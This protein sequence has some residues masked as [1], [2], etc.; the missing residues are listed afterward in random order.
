MSSQTSQ[1]ISS[2]MDAKVSG[3]SAWNKTADDVRFIT[4]ISAADLAEIEAALEHFK[5]LQRNGY[6]VDA[7]TFP[8]PTLGP[9]LD[10]IAQNLHEGTGI[11]LLRGLD[12]K[13][14]DEDYLI[15]FLGLGSYIGSQRGKKTAAFRDRR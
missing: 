11:S 15:I 8:L 4:S 7:S 9:R 6:E 2:K 13:Y 12:T 5:A 3:P 1:E 14:S 10:A